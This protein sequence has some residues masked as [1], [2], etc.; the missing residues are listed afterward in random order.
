MNT[1]EKARRRLD[2]ANAAM[3]ML[4]EKTI[5]ANPSGVVVAQIMDVQAFDRLSDAVVRLQ[6]RALEDVGT[7]AA[8]PAQPPIAPNP[9]DYR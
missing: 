9:H 7:D 2:L 5:P 6:S 3:D 8:L 4:I 1:A